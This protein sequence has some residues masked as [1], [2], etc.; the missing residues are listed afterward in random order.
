M[1]G[2]RMAVGKGIMKFHID[3]ARHHGIADKAEQGL[4]R[5]LVHHHAWRHDMSLYELHVNP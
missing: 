1:S 2:H 5:A 3:M 4:H